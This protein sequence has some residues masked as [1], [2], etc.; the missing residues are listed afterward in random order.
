MEQTI[1]TVQTVS[2]IPLLTKLEA[3]RSVV[4]ECEENAAFWLALGRADRAQFWL[5]VGAAAAVVVRGIEATG[6][7]DFLPF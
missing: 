2:T 3:E 6:N 4:A 5:D 1:E 7:D